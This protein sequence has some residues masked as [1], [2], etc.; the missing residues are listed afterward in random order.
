MMAGFLS[1]HRRAV[2]A[3]CVAL[4][5]VGGWFSLRPN[6]RPAPPAPATQPPAL[7]EHLQAM[8]GSAH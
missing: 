6:G 7:V 5:A 3:A 4:L 8:Q 2:A 1:R